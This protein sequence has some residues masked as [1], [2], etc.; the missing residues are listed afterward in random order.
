MPFLRQK[1]GFGFGLAERPRQSLQ[2]APDRMVD[3]GVF[4]ANDDAEALAAKLGEAG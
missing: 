4:G 3:H 2:P 1:Y